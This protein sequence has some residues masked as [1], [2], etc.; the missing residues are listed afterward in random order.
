MLHLLRTNSE[1]VDFRKLIVLLDQDL[2]EKD[3]DDHAFFSQFNKVDTIHHVIVAYQGDSAVGCGAIKKYDAVTAEIKRMFVHP[4]YRGQGIAKSILN[5]LEKW[6]FEL[7]FSYCI[8]ETGKKQVDAI[9]LYKKCNYK[10][11]PNYG[12]YIDVDSSICM[13]KKI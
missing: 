6:A 1:H 12:Q 11:I 7:G 2:K 3:G 4:D 13:S 10:M 8:L 9:A 5:D